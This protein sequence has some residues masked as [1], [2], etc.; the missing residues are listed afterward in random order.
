MSVELF[1]IERCAASGALHW[2][3]SGRLATLGA[4]PDS[5]LLQAHDPA[6][7]ISAIGWRE[8]LAALI[9]AGG[10]SPAAPT[11]A[12]SNGITQ[13]VMQTAKTIGPF[14]NPWQNPLSKSPPG[15]RHPQAYTVPTRSAHRCRC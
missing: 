1:G 6:A 9:A 3:R 5:H 8:G 4:E 13:P 11:A 7:K 12:T 15:F 2:R 10:F 14:R